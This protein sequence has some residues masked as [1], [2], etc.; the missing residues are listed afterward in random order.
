MF[1]RRKNSSK[2]SKNLLNSTNE[3]I[4]KHHIRNSCCEFNSSMKFK[5]KKNY[6]INFFNT[7]WYKNHHIF[8]NLMVRVF[9]AICKKKKFKFLQWK[10]MMDLCVF[11][12]RFYG[13][14]HNMQKCN[15]QY[16]KIG[17]S[18]EIHN[19]FFIDEDFRTIKILIVISIKKFI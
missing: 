8:R 10:F 12:F 5:K 2:N 9:G 15:M 18:I 1:Y 13:K 19:G 16:A 7:L 4:L 11:F 3:L 6:S 17:L 14:I